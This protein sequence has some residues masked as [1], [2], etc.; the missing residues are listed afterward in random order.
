MSAPRHFREHKAAE[1]FC[2][3]MQLLALE[4][5]MGTP[6]RHLDVLVELLELL[7]EQCGN[8]IRTDAFR[9]ELSHAKRR[10]DTRGNLRLVQPR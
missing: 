3:N 7:V 1:R 5:T 2:R 9:A 6:R 10:V 8:S 4:L